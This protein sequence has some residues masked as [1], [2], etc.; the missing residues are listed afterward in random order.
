M[1]KQSFVTHSA[2]QTQ[3]VA[4]QFSRRLA[5]GDT[6]A[7]RGDLGTGKTCFAKGVIASLCGL[8][9]NSVT[10]PTFTLIE[11][12]G[13]SQKVYHVDLYRLENPREA[14]ELPW[15]DLFA[16]ESITLVEWPENVKNII[17]HCKYE[18]NFIKTDE[19]E[20][21]IEIIERTPQ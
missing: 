5:K 18:I 15:D 19:K 20:R 7:L 6:I 8:D 2:E 16:K 13:S 3:T 10:S 17:S 11:E 1:V 12:Y 4:R 9:V 14:E 21:R